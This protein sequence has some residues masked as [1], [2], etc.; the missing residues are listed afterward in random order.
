MT[1][2]LEF[3]NVTVTGGRRVILDI[4]HLCHPQGQ[5]LAVLGRNGAGKSTLLRVTGGLRRHDTGRILLDGS[6][7]RA[8]DRRAVSAAVLQRPLLRRGS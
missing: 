2:L 4:E 8:A 6:D 1:P 3:R 5:V 7:S